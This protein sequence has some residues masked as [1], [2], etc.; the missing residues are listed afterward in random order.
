MNS[1]A[2]HLLQV[3]TNIT[4]Q[5]RV[6]TRIHSVALTLC[7]I[8]ICALFLI[9]TCSNLVVLLSFFDPALRKYRNH[10]DFMTLN[11]SLCDLLV[12]CISGPALALAL[13]LGARSAA[14][15]PRCHGAQLL[16]SAFP[17]LSIQTVTAIAVQRLFLVL[18]HRRDK[19]TNPILVLLVVLLLCTLGLA[20]SASAALN[21]APANAHGACT[22]FGPT[23]ARRSMAVQLYAAEFLVCTCVVTMAYGFISH[24]L[25]CRAHIH[26]C[27]IMTVKEE[28][29]GA[30]SPHS[31]VPQ[32]TT[33]SFKLHHPPRVTYMSKDSKA[34]ATC[35]LITLST[36][37]CCT[38]IVV[39]LVLQ[40]F[41]SCGELWLSQVRACAF[42]LLFA[43]SGLNPFLYARCS[44]GLRQRLSMLLICLHQRQETPPGQVL[45]EQREA[46][47][48]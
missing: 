22:I 11:L 26:K 7:T 30:P 16:S 20:T 3:N 36:L 41:G 2:S 1:T 25:L 42:T 40:T 19:G 21:V 12:S 47:S 5:L 10:F 31:V 35:V 4:S 32:V 34:L 23:P 9:G 13:L 27:A 29:I 8:V 46:F 18:G 15:P 24:V 37:V 38:P 45:Q 44:T 14:P 43:K 6:G 33:A 39:A 17:L 48:A 28:H